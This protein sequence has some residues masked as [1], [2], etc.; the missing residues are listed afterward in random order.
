MRILKYKHIIWDWNGTLL[1]DA[2]LCVEII[3][4]LLA[5]RQLPKIS[6]DDYQQIFTFPVIEYYQKLG[7]DF[8]NE[9]FESISTEFIE[10]YKV[11]CNQCELRQGAL[12]ILNRIF[13]SRVTQ[14][15]LS[16]SKQSDLSQTLTEFGL[17][18]FF[19]AINGLDNHHASSKLEAGKAYIAKQNFHSTDVLMIGDTIHDVEVA[20]EIGVDCYL[21][22]SG[23]QSHE[24]LSTCGVQMINNLSEL[25]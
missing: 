19:T 11:R 24:R 17:Y 4:S 3:N 7:F 10:E 12:R 20:E 25:F 9:P 18:Q 8:S 23:H 5:K 22:P 16:A 1:D 14:S 21:I 13:Q 2:W 6:R 15:V